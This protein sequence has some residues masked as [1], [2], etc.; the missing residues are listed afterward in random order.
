[1]YFLRH[2]NEVD[3]LYATLPFNILA[4]FVFR[5]AGGRWKIGDVQTYWPDVIPFGARLRSLGSPLFV[6]WRK[7]FNWAVAS[8]DVM[9]AVSD[10]F[11]QETTKYVSP[12]CKCRRFYLAEVDLLRDVPRREV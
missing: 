10:S 8:A 12:D 7:F 6:F 11:F 4:W 9:M 2:R 1:M 5:N 3:I